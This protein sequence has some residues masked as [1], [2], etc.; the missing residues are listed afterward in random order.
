MKMSNTQLL[1][2]QIWLE[3]GPIP[4]KRRNAKSPNLMPTPYQKAD[5]KAD[6]KKQTTLHYKWKLIMGE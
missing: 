6:R 1:K 3:T 4:C 5:R 2:K